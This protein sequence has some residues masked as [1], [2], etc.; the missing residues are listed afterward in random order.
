MLGPAI[1]QKARIFVVL[2]LYNNKGLNKL[3]NVIN[4]LLETH[5]NWLTSLTVNWESMLVMLTRLGTLVH[6]TELHLS[7]ELIKPW[8]DIC[9]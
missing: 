1:K 4:Y 5:V 8:I 9:E 3:I 6:P 7:L 2:Y